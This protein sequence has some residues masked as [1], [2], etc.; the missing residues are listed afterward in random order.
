MSCLLGCGVMHLFHFLQQRYLSDC[1]GIETVPPCSKA[2]LCQAYIIK[3][4]LQ[5][6]LIWPFVLFHSEL[7]SETLNTFT[8][9]RI[10][11]RGIGALK[12]LYLYQVADHRNKAATYVMPRVRFEPT[13]S[14]VQNCEHLNVR[15]NCSCSVLCASVNVDGFTSVRTSRAIDR[16]HG[17]EG[18]FT[19]HTRTYT[20]THTHTHTRQ[21]SPHVPAA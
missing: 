2:R 4:L 10:L 12:D 8:L 6:L 21:Q 20:H 14:G 11:G 16:S 9:V 19:V 15:P 17:Q 5:P 1:S 3:F 18:F 7:T 13:L